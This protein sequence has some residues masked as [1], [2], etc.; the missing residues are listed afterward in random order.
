MQNIGGYDGIKL[1]SL[2][3]KRV[4]VGLLARHVL[5]PGVLNPLLQRRTA[6]LANSSILG[7]GRP[8]THFNEA[9]YLRACRSQ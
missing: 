8:S 2:V 5:E 1:A 3:L 4:N 7:S 9:S 6:S